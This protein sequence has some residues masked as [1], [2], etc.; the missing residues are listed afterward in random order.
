LCVLYQVNDDAKTVEID[1]K[2]FKTG[3]WLS[4]NGNTGEVIEGKETLAPPSISG[5]LRFFL[6]L[7][8]ADFAFVDHD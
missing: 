5:D 4:L 2:I 1:G 7:I 8:F 6:H 3:D